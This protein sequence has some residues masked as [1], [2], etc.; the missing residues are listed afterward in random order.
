MEQEDTMDFKALRAKF[1]DEE[2]LL[3]QPK[4]KPA[5]PEKPKVVPPPQSPTYHL[6]AGARPSLLTSI[7]QSLEGKTPIAP[8]VV[9]KDDKKESKKPLIQ[10][11]SKGKEKSE[12]KLKGKTTKGGKEKPDANGKTDLLDQ[13]QKAES[14]TDKKLLPDLPKAATGELVPATPP[15][16]ATS[17]KKKGF[18]G[19][20]KSVKKEVTEVAT[21]PILDAPSPDVPGL[22]PLIPVPSNF[23]DATPEPAAETQ[24]PKALLPEIPTLPDSDIAATVTQPSPI[25]DSADINSPPAFIPGTPAL[26]AR[27]PENETP[28]EIE[29]P[30]APVSLSPTPATP[31]SDILTPPSPVPSPPTRHT[32]LVVSSPPSASTPS[33]PPPEPEVAAVAEVEVTD[34]AAVEKPPSPAKDPPSSPKAERSISALSFLERAEEMS[35]VKRSTPADQRI[36]NALE[37][38]RRKTISPQTN[39]TSSYSITP[40]PEELPPRQSPTLSVPELPPIDYEDQAG[41]A[42]AVKP[43]EVN[44]IEHISEGVP[45]DGPDPIPELMIV[46]PPPPRKTLPEPP[47]PAPQK[48][49]RPPT[50][51]LSSFLPPALEDNEI[52][53]PPQF[54][55]ADTSAEIP[56]FESSD[57]Y[58]PELPV[59]EWGNGEYA[60][61][62]SPDRHTLPETMNDFYSNGITAPEVHG[63]PEFGVE[64]QDIPQ[65][66]PAVKV[67]DSPSPV[68][69]D[70]QPTPGPQVEDGTKE[71]GDG[72]YEDIITTTTK[73][74]GKSEGGKKRKGPPKN[75]YAETP[76][77]TNEEKVKTGRFGKNDKKTTPEGPDE[78]E[79]K[80]KEKQ[81]L[82][83]EKKELKEQKEREKKE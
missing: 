68:S 46:P 42:L 23:D 5:L 52:P 3:K 77:P 19:F 1:Q 69:H 59:S 74:K 18:L 54:S 48:P 51:D 38:A 82:E 43:V 61:P 75:P 81:R 27:T 10:S 78:K 35:P 16:K 64:F 37:K 24:P 80:K 72:V 22:A 63:E 62:D 73:K 40:P 11:N 14:R 56:E 4:T 79:L 15:P 34:T 60:G 83:K 26:K 66:E 36:L 2:L 30:V 57:A 28:P 39:N 33:P 70:T 76:Q 6:P 50:V 47:G 8:R 7:N 67:V 29:T 32:Q 9:F 41:N 55:E 20:K 44:G 21:D 58:S 71:T 17:S 53:A 45:E 31:T 13:K 49:P 65:Y 12:G 25:P